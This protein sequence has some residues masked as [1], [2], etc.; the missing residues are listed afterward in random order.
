MRSHAR[1]DLYAKALIVV[2]FGSLAV[3][4]AI[5]DSW[6]RAG[7]LPDVGSPAMASV[8]S[9]VLTMVVVPGF[10]S[11]ALAG[12]SFTLAGPTASAPSQPRTVQVPLVQD[13]LPTRLG[14]PRV[15][16]QMLALPAHPGVPEHAFAVARLLP[17]P[18]AEPR[19]LT[20][21]LA[22]ESLA[23]NE[24]DGGFFSGMLRKT[25]S[26]VSRTG[27]S[28]TTSVGKAGSSLA[29][30]GSSLVGAFRFVGETVKRAF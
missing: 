16:T 6:P 10:T 30:A 11:T 29:E 9:S 21:D 14:V 4:G 5:V 17:P 24:D 8:S 19:R 13:R 15:R 3:T 20:D 22:T 7:R 25:S 18:A 27:A 26:S 2:G 28:V 1:V 12:T 23:L